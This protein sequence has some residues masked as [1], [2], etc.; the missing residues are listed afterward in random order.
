MS[1]C[2]KGVVTG[3]GIEVRLL[4]SETLGDQAYLYLSS[5]NSDD[6]ENMPLAKKAKSAAATK[7]HTSEASLVIVSS[8]DNEDSPIKRG[9]KRKRNPG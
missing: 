2:P 9:T 3:E 1:N 4:K 8:T 6:E 7:R 5:D